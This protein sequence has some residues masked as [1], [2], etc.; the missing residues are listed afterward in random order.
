MIGGFSGWIFRQDDGFRYALESRRWRMTAKKTQRR[1]TR[2]ARTSGPELTLSDRLRDERKQQDL[3]IRALADHSG[4]GE[5]SIQGYEAGRSL[6]GAS[7]LR[8]L[9][10]ALDVS[11]DYLVFGSDAKSP[12]RAPV[13]SFFDV[14]E[15]DD[16]YTFRVGVALLALSESDRAAVHQLLTSMLLGHIGR[17]RFERLKIV[18]SDQLTRI[19]VDAAYEPMLEVHLDEEARKKLAAQYRQAA[20]DLLSGGSGVVRQGGIRNSVADVVADGEPPAKTGA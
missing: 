5:R 3:S 16:V 6:P 8:R 2:L 17:E 15:Y 10:V 11:V 9:A 19:T 7:E 1:G 14:G 12:A 13:E 20:E 18:A 4:V